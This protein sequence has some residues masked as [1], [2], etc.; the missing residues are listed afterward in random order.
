MTMTT[1]TTTPMAHTM[2]WIPS[3]NQRCTHLPVYLI[4]GRIEDHTDPASGSAPLPRKSF[5]WQH[6]ILVL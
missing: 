1:N 6:M 2:G 5:Y 4:T 3:P